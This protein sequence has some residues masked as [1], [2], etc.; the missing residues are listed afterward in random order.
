MMVEEDAVASAA[1]LAEPV[2]LLLEYPLWNPHSG[3]DQLYSTGKI[4]ST[5]R[6]A[7]YIAVLLL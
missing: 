1:T 6:I 5:A 4:N 7:P 2:T 3:D